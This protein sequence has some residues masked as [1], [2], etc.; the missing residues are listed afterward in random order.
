MPYDDRAAGGTGDLNLPQIGWLGAKMKNWT[1]WAA[2]AHRR[3]PRTGLAGGS[4]QP[5]IDLCQRTSIVYGAWL[6][7]QFHLSLTA[8]GLLSV[9][10]CLAEF[11]AEGFSAGWVDRIG[12]RRAVMG[13]LILNVLAYLLLPRLAGS[14]AGALVGLF[15]VYLTFDFS[16]MSA[17]SQFQAARSTS[18]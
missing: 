1:L 4:C 11:S 7:G 6:E 12:K 8:L 14:L 5:V 10:I 15:L 18:T 13:G 17:V 3:D 2:Q 16:I 9:V